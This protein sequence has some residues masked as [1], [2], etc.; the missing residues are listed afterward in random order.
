MQESSEL[1]LP[2][3]DPRPSKRL[4]RILEELPRCNDLHQTTHVLPDMLRILPLF[5]SVAANDLSRTAAAS[6]FSD[7]ELQE[8]D[9]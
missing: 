8:L 5:D 9:R 6:A 4:R 3:D 7:I 2:Y 1:V